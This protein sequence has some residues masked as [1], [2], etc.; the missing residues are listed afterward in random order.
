MVLLTESWATKV[1]TEQGVGIRSSRS[2]PTRLDDHNLFLISI[3]MVTFFCVSLSLLVL[4]TGAG[5]SS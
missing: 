2:I 3:F 5:L 1:P 4:S